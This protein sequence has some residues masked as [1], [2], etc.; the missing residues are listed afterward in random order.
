MLNFLEGAAWFLT[1][2]VVLKLLDY[3]VP[4][5]HHLERFTEPPATEQTTPQTLPPEPPT[6]QNFLE[7]WSSADNQ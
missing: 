2:A 3:Q 6:A 1:I 5:A 7:D 4:F